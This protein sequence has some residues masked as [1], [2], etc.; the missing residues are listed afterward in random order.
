HTSR[1]LS[2]WRKFRA[3]SMAL[4]GRQRKR[5]ISRPTR[6]PRVYSRR[7]IKSHTKLS[8]SPASCNVSGA[9]GA[10]G[11]VLPSQ[12]MSDAFDDVKVTVPTPS[13]KVR[14]ERDGNPKGGLRLSP[15]D[16]PQAQ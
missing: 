9:R 5:D 16:D 7:R 13:A 2:F 3:S 8:D 6:A 11:A 15:P 4:N 14:G 10:S 12:S 1:H